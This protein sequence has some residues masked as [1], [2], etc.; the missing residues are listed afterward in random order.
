MFIV[1]NWKMHMLLEPAVKLALG[2]EKTATEHPEVH[3]WIAPPFT[4]LHAVRDISLQRVKYGAQ[5]VHWEPHGAFTGEISSS[6][7]KELG[8]CFAIT[9]HSERRQY[10]NESDATVNKRTLQTLKEGLVPILCI[11]ETLS[12]REAKETEKVLSRQLKG[13]LEGLQ[14]S[15]LQALGTA[16]LLIAY[17]PVWAIGTGKVATES[18]IEAAH[19]FIRKELQL[20]GFSE[21]ESNGGQTKKTPPILYGGSV[22]PENFE[23]IARIPNV[24]GALV[25]GASLQ[26]ESFSELVKIAA[27]VE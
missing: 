18:E 5:N 23:G 20:L 10:F 3:A 12:E 13:G 16:P 17:E 6:M 25:G 21:T 15:W 4:A 14:T 27:R 8:C 19:S 24:G 11:G 2:I 22:K 1:G 7:L 26:L 9:G